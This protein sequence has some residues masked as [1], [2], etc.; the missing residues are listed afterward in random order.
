MFWS[1]EK[2]S[3]DEFKVSEDV[4]DLSFKLICKTLPLEHAHA[5]FE[6]IKTVLNWL[7]EEELAGIHQIHVAESGNGW[8]RPDDPT[9]EVLHLSRR[10]RMTLRMPKQ[11]IEAAQQLTGKTLDI[12]GYSLTIGEASIKPFIALPTLFSRYVACDAGQS[13][14]Q[15][16]QLVAKQLQDMGIPVMKMLAGKQ[17]VI[18]TPDQEINTRSIMVADLDKEH[19]VILQQR[20]IGPGRKLGCGLFLPQKGIKAVKE[21][22]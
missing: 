17:N 12:Q 4:V 20:G 9:N 18:K 2:S 16:L 5:L 22:S 11:R 7:E 15:F 14:E 1:E 19:S 13:E 21:T 3:K 6:A 8:M 10:T